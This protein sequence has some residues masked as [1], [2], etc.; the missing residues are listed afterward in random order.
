MGQTSEAGHRDER[1]DAAKVFVSFNRGAL[2]PMHQ[3]REVRDRDGRAER[4][5]NLNDIR[6]RGWSVAFEAFG[7]CEERDLYD[8]KFRCRRE[9][10]IARGGEDAPAAKR[11]EEPHGTK[12]QQQRR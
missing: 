5:E 2:A 9:K 4:D 3:L 11:S 12:S 8:R 10:R 1:T 6:E 7:Q